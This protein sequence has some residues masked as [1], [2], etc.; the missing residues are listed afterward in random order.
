MGK[1]ENELVYTATVRPPLPPNPTRAS[2][3][4]VT[5]RIPAPPCIRWPPVGTNWTL[6]KWK[7]GSYF[8]Q[9]SQMSETEPIVLTRAQKMYTYISA[10]RIR[11]ISRAARDSLQCV[12]AMRLV[13]SARRLMAPFAAGADLCVCNM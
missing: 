12:R 8:S 1:I 2:D 6:S 5:R 3:T 11:R 13:I 9:M 7:S 4:R 10:N